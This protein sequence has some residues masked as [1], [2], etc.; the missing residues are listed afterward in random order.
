MNNSKYR[1]KELK[2]K[3]LASNLVELIHI[4]RPFQYYDDS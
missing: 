2:K 1:D 4:K 3:G